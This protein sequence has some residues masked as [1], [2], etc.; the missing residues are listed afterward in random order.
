MRLII[1][2][3][4]PSLIQ[5]SALKNLLKTELENALDED[6]KAE[7]RQKYQNIFSQTG[8]KIPAD[9]CND[10]LLLICSQDSVKQV[11]P[12]DVSFG[13]RSLMTA[14]LIVAIA[15]EYR[16]SEILLI[17]DENE[18]TLQMKRR[19]NSFGLYVR[20]FIGSQLINDDVDHCKNE[21]MQYYSHSL[22]IPTLTQQYSIDKT[23]AYINAF[24]QCG[25]I[26]EE[27]YFLL[28]SQESLLSQDEVDR[29]RGFDIGSN[30]WIISRD[31]SDSEPA[32]INIYEVYRRIPEENHR[33]GLMSVW[34]PS[35]G[36]VASKADKWQRRRNLKGIEIKIASLPVTL[37]QNTVLAG[38]NE[39]GFNESSRFN[40]SVLT[41]K[42]FFTS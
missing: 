15:R 31:D 34:S 22:I 7:I 30:F 24:S 38:F 13:D 4:F 20:L 17:F 18:E 10:G 11:A 2:F 21:K 41:S 12:K 19:L 16:L 14:D 29:F 6:E 27:N 35:L 42:V 9:F 3:L 40:E 32:I 33:I 25:L 5:G 23:T 36:L 37:Q 26:S 39:F 28:P 8:E 1:L